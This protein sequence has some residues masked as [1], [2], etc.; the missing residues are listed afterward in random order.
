MNAAGKARAAAG[1][2]DAASAA[3]EKRRLELQVVK[4]E[5]EAAMAE[6]L[7]L[8]RPR[9]K[10]REGAEAALGKRETAELFER[11]K[12]QEALGEQYAAGERIKGVGFG[13]R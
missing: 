8:A 5:E 13:V 7:G 6:M 10:A 2:G 3:A 9:R 4:E 1:G 11:G 12:A